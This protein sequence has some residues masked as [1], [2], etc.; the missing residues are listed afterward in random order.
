MTDELKFN[1]SISDNKL[2]TTKNSTNKKIIEN[3]IELTQG[4]FLLTFISPT[5]IKN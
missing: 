4:Q 3:R 2:K 5:F 1:Y